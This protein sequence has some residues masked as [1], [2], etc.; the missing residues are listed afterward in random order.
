MMKLLSVSVTALIMSVGLA[1]AQAP[2]Q[3]PAGGGADFRAGEGR[4]Q[5]EG[6]TERIERRQQRMEQQ[7]TQV[8]RG[9]RGGQRQEDRAERRWDN[10]GRGGSTVRV[11][12]DRDDRVGRRPGGRY[13]ERVVI[14]DRG[15]T[16]RYGIGP[17]I[18]IR[19]LPVRYR[20]VYVGGR[21]CRITITRRVR[22]NGRIVTTE[23]RRCPGRPAV[24]IQ[25][26]R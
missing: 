22:A 26:R 23:T 14:R 10:E 12:R 20:T 8:D 18:F 9:G 25:T 19:T 15:P 11:E 5:Q 1:A 24:V 3:P 6:G 4:R 21:P 13:D 17:D 2:M 7:E 16:V